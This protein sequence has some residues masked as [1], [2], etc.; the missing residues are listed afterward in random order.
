VQFLLAQ[1][2]GLANSISSQKL[3]VCVLT[4]MAQICV[5]RLTDEL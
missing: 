2:D 4:R 3:S 5:H 1:L